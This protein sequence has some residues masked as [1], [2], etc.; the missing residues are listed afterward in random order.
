MVTGG[1]PPDVVQ[2]PQLPEALS[3]ATLLSRSCLRS[4]TSKPMHATECRAM[5]L[6]PHTHPPCQPLTPGGSEECSCWAMRLGWSVC[7]ACDGLQ[8][9]MLLQPLGLLRS[10]SQLSPLYLLHKILMAQL[11]EQ[12][13]VAD[14]LIYPSSVLKWLL[15]SHC[16][17]I[18]SYWV[19]QYK[20]S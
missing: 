9:S 12:F 17:K 14:S 19:S 20:N 5:R 3:S 6:E 18:H 2:G 8:Q 4:G 16:R 10:K 7:S 13:A 1:W 15:I 11:E